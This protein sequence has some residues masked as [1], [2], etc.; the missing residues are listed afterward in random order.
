MVVTRIKVRNS[1]YCN[2]IQSLMNGVASL[3][4]RGALKSGES[5]IVYEGK[6]RRKELFPPEGALL[7]KATVK[8]QKLL[9]N[10]RKKKWEIT[11]INLLLV[12]EM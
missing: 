3:P 1:K 8:I 2:T 11:W 4:N 6:R 10:K 12:V 5:F 7:Y 9:N